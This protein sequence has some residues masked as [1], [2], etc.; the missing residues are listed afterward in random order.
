MNENTHM[1]MIFG[2]HGDQR[3]E[4]TE[5]TVSRKHCKVT[6]L[7]GG[8]QVEIENLSPNGTFI[9]GVR[10]EGKAVVSPHAVI[11]LGPFFKA[12]V[13]ELLVP[14]DGFVLEVPK[15]PSLDPE[16][17]AKYTHYQLVLA[18]YKHLN[19]LT[20]LRAAVEKDAGA[21][22]P[23]VLPV[24]QTSIASKYLRSGKA[25]DAQKLLYKT[26]DAVFELLKT[27]RK[28]ELEGCYATMMALLSELYYSVS[29]Y[30]EAELAG[31]NAV[32]IY[33]RWKPGDPGITS[34]RVADVYVT[35]ADA[36]V[37]N[38]KIKQARRCYEHAIG[39]FRDSG[40]AD[41]SFYSAKIVEV[42]IKL[43]DWC[44]E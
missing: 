14:K 7:E 11:G 38:G 2:R 40:S 6:L 5:K 29:K 34:S 10:I 1:E 20:D 4:I 33:N 25:R 42:Q 21:Y 18:D 36:L 13:S 9:D 15:S 12:K 26:G 31:R 23:Y 24:I 3:L 8:K 32:G 22:P 30:P 37:A 35:Y 41:P 17:I 39:L 44:R 43:D 19:D 16:R 27:E 28:P